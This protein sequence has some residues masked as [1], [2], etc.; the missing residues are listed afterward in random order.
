M[1]PR[2]DDASW[3]VIGGSTR[4]DNLSLRPE[5]PA[6]CVAIDRARLHRH[7]AA[8]VIDIHEPERIASRMRAP[9]VKP[10]PDARGDVIMPPAALLRNFVSFYHQAYR[11][12]VWD[13]VK[14]S[15]T[16]MAKYGHRS[17]AAC[18]PMMD[19]TRSVYWL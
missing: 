12:A 18:A 19:K 8:K 11:V 15:V 3:P 16:Y 6:L 5:P 1:Q 7:H 14:I 2:G 10:R 9:G 4:R 17:Y 13:L